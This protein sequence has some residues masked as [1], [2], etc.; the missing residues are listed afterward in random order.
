MATGAAADS[1]AAA[2]FAG[3]G[4]NGAATVCALLLRGTNAPRS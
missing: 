4:G 2:G 1:R 3:V